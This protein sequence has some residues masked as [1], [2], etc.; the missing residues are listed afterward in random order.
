M[1]QLSRRRS[2]HDRETWY[3]YCGD[4]R[5]GTISK[6]A[7][8][9]AGVDQWG[10]SCGFYPGFEPGEHQSGSAL[11]FGHSRR[12]ALRSTPHGNGYFRI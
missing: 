11:T 3:V 7:G 8:I 5:V 9:P 4:V 6:R 10:W 1:P 2:Q 12:R